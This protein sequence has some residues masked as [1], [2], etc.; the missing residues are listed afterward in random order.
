MARDGTTPKTD[1]LELSDDDTEALFASPSPKGRSKS[2]KTSA[3]QTTD[4]QSRR[5]E[6]QELNDEEAHG[7][8]LRKELA[9][10]RNINQ[11]IEGAINGLERAASNVDT[12]SHTV[13]DASVLLNTWTRILSQTEHNQRLILDPSWGGASQDVADMENESIIKQQE[14]DRR[15]LEEAQR[16]EARARK[17]EEDERKRAENAGAKVPRGGRGRGRLVSRGGGSGQVSRQGSSA[18]AAKIASSQ[19]ARAG[20][21]IGRG[22]TGS[23]GRPRGA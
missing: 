23:R 8:A 4:Q 14:K 18:A 21:S 20:S 3:Q 13:N 22:P 5:L 1:A 11:V 2:S 9:G 7:T 10:I 12:V 17:A 19:V 16:R 15:E 6:D